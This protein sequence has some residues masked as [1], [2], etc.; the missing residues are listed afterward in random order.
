MRPVSWRS[1]GGR[2]GTVWEVKAA[3]NW[4]TKMESQIGDRK[5]RHSLK[6]VI[7][8]SN[9]YISEVMLYPSLSLSHNLFPIT[10]VYF[11]EGNTPESDI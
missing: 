2:L 8:S 10:L 4:L 5:A 7:T 11:Q 1:R 9:T 6:G 3:A